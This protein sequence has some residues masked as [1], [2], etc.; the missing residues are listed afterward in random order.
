M[1]MLG[2]VAVPILDRPLRSGGRIQQCGFGGGKFMATEGIVS[3]AT[4]KRIH[5]TGKIIGG[6]SGSPIFVGSV[7]AGITTARKGSYRGILF[8]RFVPSEEPAFIGTA[9]MVILVV[10][11]SKPVVEKLI[12]MFRAWRAYRQDAFPLFPGLWKRKPKVE[13][14]ITVVPIEPPPIVSSTPPPGQAPPP[15][16]S[17]IT[18]E[19]APIKVEITAGVFW[20]WIFAGPPAGF[21][22]FGTAAIILIL[23]TNHYRSK[24]S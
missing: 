7:L 20:P 12:K 18:E 14:D 16:I 2:G 5:C 10:M 3:S 9:S 21:F 1:R 13:P 17:K 23:S 24:L 15:I 19:V 22:L 4:D 11:Y 8:K 6:D